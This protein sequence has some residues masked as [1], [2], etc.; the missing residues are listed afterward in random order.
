MAQEYHALLALLLLQSHLYGHQGVISG[1][2]F[3]GHRP[4]ALRDRWKAER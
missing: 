1:V 3:G 4:S 2:G